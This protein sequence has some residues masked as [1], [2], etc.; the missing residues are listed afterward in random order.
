MEIRLEC[1]R[2]ALVVKLDGT[3]WAWGDNRS[4]QIGDGT[5]E[6]RRTPVRVTFPAQ[7]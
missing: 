5:T 3:L 6:R 7:R 4:G 1:A 2:D